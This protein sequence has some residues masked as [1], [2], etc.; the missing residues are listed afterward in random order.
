LPAPELRDLLAGE[1][2]ARLATVS[3]DG[4]PHLV[5]ICFAVAG[6]TVYSAVDAKPK[7]TQRL[8]RLANARATGRA[9]LLADR[10]DEDW[11]RL[12]WVRADGAARVLEAGEE[13]DRALA[14]LAEKYEQYR[15]QPP[16]GAVLA[17]DVERW[18]GWRGRA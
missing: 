12:W 8:Q 18:S 15:R 16:T 17:L 6:D 4:S 3:A 2:V 13:R 9:A 10:W 11:S 7:R 5:P 1:R 14:L